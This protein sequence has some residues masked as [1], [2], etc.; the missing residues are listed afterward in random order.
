MKDPELKSWTSH[1]NVL[2]VAK[3]NTTPKKVLGIIAYKKL[4]QDTVEMGRWVL[5]SSKSKSDTVFL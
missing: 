3:S 2:L 1:P 4:S 5:K